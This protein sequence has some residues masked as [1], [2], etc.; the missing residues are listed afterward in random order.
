VRAGDPRVRPRVFSRAARRG[1]RSGLARDAGLERRPLDDLETTGYV[2][3][4]EVFDHR[5][6]LAALAA[7]ST[8]ITGWKVTD[9]RERTGVR[10]L[11]LHT[12]G[13]Q[14]TTLAAHLVIAADGATSIMRRVLTGQGG[15]DHARAAIAL[16]AYAEARTPGPGLHLE[17][18]AVLRPSYGWAFP[19]SGTSVN[20]GL[21]GPAHLLRRRGIDLRAELDRH[22]DRLRAGGLEIGEL[23]R[24]KGSYLP[25]FAGQPGLAHS[26]AVLLGDAASMINPVSGEGIAY[27]MAAALALIDVLPDRLEHYGMLDAGLTEFERAFRVGHRRHV[28]TCLIVQRLMRNRTVSTMMIDAM[29]RDPDLFDSVVAMMFEAGS[30][31]GADILRGLTSRLRPLPRPDSRLRP[32]SRA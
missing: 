6:Y 8:G 14:P 12:R 31:S 17:F 22:A 7:G 27:A 21:G 16:R 10:E 2:V 3:P 5:L 4:R 13:E 1:G 26:R 32:G 25:H 24:V 29:G 28:R 19:A 11:V 23:L 30:L 9:T 20:L 18:T 15:I